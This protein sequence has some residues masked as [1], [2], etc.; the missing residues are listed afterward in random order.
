MAVGLLN[1]YERGEDEEDGRRE[2]ERGLETLKGEQWVAAV[3]RD[4]PV[5]L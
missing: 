5:D 3:D 2:D 4:G 1:K